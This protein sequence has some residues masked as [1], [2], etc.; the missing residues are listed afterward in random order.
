M[1]VRIIISINVAVF[2]LWFYSMG[3]PVA[4]TWMIDNFLVSW[5]ALIEKRPWVLITS[6]FSHNSFFHLFINMY[7]LRSFGMVISQLMGKFNFLNFY[8]LAAVS[9]SFTHAIVSL[10][11]L[12]APELPALGAS[13][14]IAGIILLFSL[15]FPREKLLLLGLIP[16]RAG[17]AAVLIIGIDIWGVVEQSSGGGLPIG[18]G[19][20]LG[21]ALI[22]ILWYLLVMRNRK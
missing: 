10:L 3:N 22:G 1:V 7:V 19:A 17:W 4:L 9:G 8:L 16:I 15:M 12:N 14:A 20:H 6:A 13:G 18:H 2:L 21:G 11:L 5:K